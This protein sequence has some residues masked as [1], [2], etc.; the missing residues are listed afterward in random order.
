METKTENKVKIL[1]EVVGI[2][3]L[4][5]FIQLAVTIAFT[6]V[7]MLTVSTADKG[8]VLNKATELQP[9]MVLISNLIITIVF[10]IWYYLGYVR[11]NKLEGT[12]EPWQKKICDA[13]S[14]AFIV[15]TTLA[16]GLLDGQIA[17]FV[18]RITHGGGDL[19]SQIA[20]VFHEVT[21]MNIISMVLLAPMATAFAFSGIIFQ[22]MKKSFGM[23]GCIIIPAILLAISMLNPVQMIYG[24]PLDL[25][26]M[27]VSYKYNSV[28]PGMLVMIINNA[29]ATILGAIFSNGVPPAVGVFIVVFFVLSI[30]L[31]RKLPL[32]RDTK[33]IH[34]HNE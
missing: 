4:Y 12:Y 29:G 7:I 24:I 26:M 10:G 5:L 25:F 23:A 27:F 18:V 13:K 20:S 17:D 21:L 3:L 31:Y 6:L 16:I 30:F 32:Y 9:V 14:I 22:K 28:L 33:D 11:K 19:Y 1:F 15:I 34:T 8:A 2:A